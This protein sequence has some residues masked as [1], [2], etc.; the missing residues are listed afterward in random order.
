MK[1]GE[2]RPENLIIR[3]PSEWRSLLLRVTRGCSWNRCRFCGIYP[4]LGEPEYSP[5]SLPEILRDIDC[6]AERSAKGETIFLGD[7]DP[8]G[9]PLPDSLEILRHIHRSLPGIRRVTAYARASTLKKIGPD[10]LRALAREG[11][12]RL[13]IGL[14]SGNKEILAFHHKGQTPELLVETGRWLREA[15]I[16]ISFYILL[17]LGGADRWEAHIDATIQVINQVDPEFI[18]LR[19]LW[20]FTGE[21]SLTGRE[22]PLLKDIREGRFVPQTAEGTVLEL[23]RLIEGL[24]GVSGLLLCDHSNNFL[25]IKGRLPTDRE[26]MLRE[27]DRFLSRPLEDR[28][29]HYRLVGSSI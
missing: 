24:D 12:H 5:R 14:E 2:Q 29:E 16:E 13:H 11:L 21:D 7:A 1:D 4:A 8:L 25:K 28:E 3:P 27:I 9:I 6:L 22:C 23:R 20:I 18:R 19:R 26:A 17:G 15:G 10:G